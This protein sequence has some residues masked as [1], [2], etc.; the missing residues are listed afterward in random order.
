MVELKRRDCIKIFEKQAEDVSRPNRESGLLNCWWTFEPFS[1]VS[2]LP[3]RRLRKPVFG[4]GPIRRARG[5]TAFEPSRSRKRTYAHPSELDQIVNLASWILG[6]LGSHL[7]RFSSFQGG[8]QESVCT[9]L[10]YFEGLVVGRIRTFEQQE[11]DVCSKP[12]TLT[13]KPTPPTPIPQPP[14]S[15]P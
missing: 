15:N 3:R 2:K 14:T 6:G 11:E 5:R 10:V 1:P 9:D 4:F 8:N 13:S 12:T 7:L